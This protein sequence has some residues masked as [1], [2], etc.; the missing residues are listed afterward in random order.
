M[1]DHPPPERRKPA[2]L[3]RDPLSKTVVVALAGI[4]CITAICL[5]TLASVMAGVTVD[6]T[7]VTLIVSMGG[8][9]MA[10]VGVVGSRAQ[11]PAVAPS[12]AARG[13]DVG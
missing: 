7:T 11:S 3:L 9:I 2:A 4:V 13:D 8:N 6:G 5:A 10:C 1:T 12:R